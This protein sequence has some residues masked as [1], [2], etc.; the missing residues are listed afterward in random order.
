MGIFDTFSPVEY[1]PRKVKFLL[2]ILLLAIISPF[3]NELL[4]MGKG[5]VV[6]D[7]Q[8]TPYV[9]TGM[10]YNDLSTSGYLTAY[11]LNAPDWV[12]RKNK[13]KWIKEK[14]ERYRYIQSTEMTTMGVM[15]PLAYKKVGGVSDTD[16]V[17]CSLGNYTDCYD[18][19]T[20]TW[21]NM[22]LVSEFVIEHWWTQLVNPFSQPYCHRGLHDYD[23]RI[24]LILVSDTDGDH[25][26]GMIYYMGVSDM[27]IDSLIHETGIKYSIKYEGET[28]DFV[29]D[30]MPVSCDRNFQPTITVLGIPIF[31]PS[32]WII[33]TIM[34]FLFKWN[35]WAKQHK[36]YN[37]T[38]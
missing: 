36:R 25:W 7:S 37:K 5:T 30:L 23:E 31:N 3:I 10:D 2:F 21:T 8:R 33:F 34:L 11:Y 17:T 18:P 13:E 35:S 28:G 19:V 26:M 22:E 9:I 14:I 16:C 38:I 24:D 15:L 4:L 12:L 6:C 32:T 1:M 29:P 27:S 20:E